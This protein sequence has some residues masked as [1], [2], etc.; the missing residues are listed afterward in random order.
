MGW[1]RVEALDLAGVRNPKVAVVGVGGGGNNAIR[2]LKDCGFDAAETIAVNTDARALDGNPADRRLLLG[3]IRLRGRGCGGG[4]GT[5]AAPAICEIVRERGG[6]AVPIC[7]LPFRV[8]KGRWRL[9]MHGLRE[10]YH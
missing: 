1:D 3:E 10:L 8:E 9:A 6:L 7:T 2:R 5:G 4:T